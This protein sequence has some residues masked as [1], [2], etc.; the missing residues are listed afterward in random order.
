MSPVAC[1]TLYFPANQVNATAVW[2]GRQCWSPEENGLSKQTYF[3][4]TTNSIPVFFFFGFWLFGVFF[5]VMPEFAQRVVCF[6]IHFCSAQQADPLLCTA[7]TVM[8][9]H[10]AHTS[11]PT[12]CHNT[13]P[14]VFKCNTASTFIVHLQCFCSQGHNNPVSDSRLQPLLL[15]L[16]GFWAYWFRNLGH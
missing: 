9:N 14:L 8:P 7:A 15:R 12:E 1:N 3:S 10:A 2:E 4:Q 16:P 13:S 11:S 5:W 6:T